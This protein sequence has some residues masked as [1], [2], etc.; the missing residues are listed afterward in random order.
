MKWF[1]LCA[2]ASF[3]L[4][5]LILIY[6]IISPFQGGVAIVLY[7]I[8]AFLVLMHGIQ[9]VIFSTTLGKTLSMTRWERWS[10]LIFGVFAV[11][12][13]R[14]RIAVGSQSGDDNINRS[15]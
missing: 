2:K 7:A 5:W 10:I 12:V 11:L 15:K 4:V 9:M 13:I 14:D 3:I 6:N 1:I 8:G